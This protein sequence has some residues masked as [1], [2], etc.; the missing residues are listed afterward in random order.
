[1]TSVVKVEL[2]CS[3][4]AGLRPGKSALHS[5]QIPTRSRWPARPADRHQQTS[6]RYAHRLRPLAI[7]LA[8]LAAVAVEAQQPET[9]RALDAQI[10]R[11]FRDRAYEAPRFGPARWLPD[12][13][14]YAVVE[15]SAAG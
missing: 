1:M 11:I 3:S 13:G 7:C 4:R 5:P 14:G 12:G 8:A 9:V 6:M 2:R 15:A 10:D